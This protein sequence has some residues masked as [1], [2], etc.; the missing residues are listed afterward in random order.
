[1]SV[2]FA[3]P[4][5]AVL[6]AENVKVLLPVVDA[7]LKLAVTPVGK[8]PTLSA[9][10]P[11]NPPEGVTVTVLVPVAPCATVAFVAASE[12]SGV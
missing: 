4:A 1:M 8:A 3:V 5:V 6:D 2:T 10:V 9:T 7:G 12:K 11:L